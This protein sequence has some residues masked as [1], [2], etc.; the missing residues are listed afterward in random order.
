MRRLVLAVVCLLAAGC[1]GSTGSAAHGGHSRSSAAQGAQRHYFLAAEE[2][3][4]DYAPLRRDAIS[5]KPF[6]RTAD[7]FVKA[8]PDRIGCRIGLSRCDT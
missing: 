1:S 8:G 3:R 2:V 7:V 4:W 5:G 6:D